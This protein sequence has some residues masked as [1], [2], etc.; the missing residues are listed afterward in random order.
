MKREIREVIIHVSDSPDDRDIGFEEIN[1]WHKER[2]EWGPWNGWVYCGYHFI[3]RR[4][5]TVEHARPD[6]VPGVHCAG[7]NAH[8]IGICWVGKTQMSP[9]QRRSLLLLV[10]SVL[11]TH[12]LGIEKVFGHK[13]FSTKTCPN[14]DIEE[15]KREL[16][17]V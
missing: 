9:E 14:I 11:E 12:K 10:K 5:G 17:T 6:D 7:H 13:D 1:Q 15:L 3:V 2:A 4:D 16:E 8:S